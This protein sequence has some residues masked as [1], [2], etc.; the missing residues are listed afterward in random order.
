VHSQRSV[1]NYFG[2]NEDRFQGT[3]LRADVISK[4]KELIIHKKGT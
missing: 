4:G 3:A 2:H 1:M